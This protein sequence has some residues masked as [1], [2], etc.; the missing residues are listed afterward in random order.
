MNEK[1][2]PGKA[3][4]VLQSVFEIPTPEEFGEVVENYLE[5][6]GKVGIS[7]EI[8]KCLKRELT[9]SYDT[10]PDQKRMLFTIVAKGID[11]LKEDMG[12]RGKE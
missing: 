3:D 1:F 4:F 12:K 10:R 8:R 6:L 5:D 9:G 2:D 7:D 11:G